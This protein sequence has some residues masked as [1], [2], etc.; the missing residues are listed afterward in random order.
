MDSLPGQ[1]TW[2]PGMWPPGRCPISRSTGERGGCSSPEGCGSSVQPA[3][4]VVTDAFLRG[5]AGRRGAL[6]RRAGRRKPQ[7]LAVLLKKGYF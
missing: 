1:I 3:S 7:Q 6:W 2:K 4:E 5:G